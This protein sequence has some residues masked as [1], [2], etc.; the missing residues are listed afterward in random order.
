MRP[1]KWTEAPVRLLHTKNVAMLLHRHIFTNNT[2]R[3]TD[4][5]PVA[6]RHDEYA[7]ANEGSCAKA[8]RDDCLKRDDD[9]LRCTPRLIGMSDCG[10]LTNLEITPPRGSSCA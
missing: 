1:K 6:E 9:D 10:M 5:E 3:R 2:V 4:N 8:M 7:P